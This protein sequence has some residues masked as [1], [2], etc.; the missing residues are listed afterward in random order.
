MFIETFKKGKEGVTFRHDTKRIEQLKKIVR[1]IAKSFSSDLNQAFAIESEVKSGDWL[2]CN[3][4]ATQL[5]LQVTNRS[6]D[7][8]QLIIGVRDS[9]EVIFCSGHKNEDTASISIKP[10]LSLKCIK[11][12]IV[13]TIIER[14][15]EEFYDEVS[16][17]STTIKEAA[18][19][20]I[21]E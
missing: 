10:E 9:A 5:E 16:E 12:L 13:K 21:I 17:L 8:V 2:L 11:D 4:I 18:I 20:D 6:W 14:L 3:G 19:Q 7:K 1:E 15:D